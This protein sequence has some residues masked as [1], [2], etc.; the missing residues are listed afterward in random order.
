MCA[1][2]AVT[3]QVNIT[4]AAPYLD[5]LCNVIC[6]VREDGLCCQ[7]ARRLLMLASVYNLKAM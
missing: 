7:L 2:C 5:E 4:Y 3:V 6:H 1:L